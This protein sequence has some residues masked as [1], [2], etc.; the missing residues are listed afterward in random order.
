MGALIVGLIA[1]ALGILLSPLAIMA[2]VAE[3]LSRR[4]RANGLAFFIGWLLATVVVVG[5]SVAVF[6]AID[7]H[8]GPTPCSGR[9]WS[10][11]S[12]HSG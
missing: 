2:L 4:Y 7:F 1:P 9:P 3:L 10:G 8:P 5:V 12:S 11:W 6:T